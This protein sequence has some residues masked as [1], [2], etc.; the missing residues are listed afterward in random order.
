MRYSVRDY[1]LPEGAGRLDRWT[2]SAWKAWTGWVRPAIAVTALMVLGHLLLSWLVGVPS[3]DANSFPYR[4]LVRWASQPTPP[5]VSQAYTGA[6]YGPSVLWWAIGAEFAAAAAAAATAFVLIRRH[7]RPALM[8]ALGGAVA[9]LLHVS[10]A[11]LWT[12]HPLGYIRTPGIAVT[13]PASVTDIHVYVGSAFQNGLAVVALWSPMALGAL[14][15][16]WLIHRRRRAP[17]D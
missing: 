5:L 8:G 11:G 15:G 14:A 10:F 7:P 9:A 13:S 2:L 12:T 16:W 4:Y 3:S 17:S 6:T 1:R